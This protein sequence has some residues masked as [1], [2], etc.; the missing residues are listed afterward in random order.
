MNIKTSAVLALLVG[1]IFL[2][3]GCTGL[4]ERVNAAKPMTGAS[5]NV[6]DLNNPHNWY[7][8]DRREF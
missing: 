1:S 8:Y 5:A 2:F 7:D 3:A 4:H 6:A